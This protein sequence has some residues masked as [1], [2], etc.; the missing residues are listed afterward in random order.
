M[1]VCVR[2][3]LYDA[4]NTGAFPGYTVNAL[5]ENRNRILPSGGVELFEGCASEEG[6]C[7]ELRYRSKW[8]F[9]YNLKGRGASKRFF[10]QGSIEEVSEKKIELH[11]TVEVWGKAKFKV[12][13][14]LGNGVWSIN[15]PIGA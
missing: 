10:G 1:S 14:A 13:F 9:W 8:R 4:P 3:V 15:N 2:F 7:K 11:F 6:G 12:S 5:M